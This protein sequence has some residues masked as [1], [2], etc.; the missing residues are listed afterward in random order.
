MG[1]ALRLPDLP[2][3]G[4]SKIPERPLTLTDYALFLDDY[5]KK[6]HIERLVQRRTF[7]KVGDYLSIF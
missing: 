3:F 6:N 2:G 7:F 1:P 5:L 4:A